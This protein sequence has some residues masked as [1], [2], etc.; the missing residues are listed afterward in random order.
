MSWVVIS[1]HGG[2]NV[3]QIPLPLVSGKDKDTL[4]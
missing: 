4:N 2:T 3:F 1:N